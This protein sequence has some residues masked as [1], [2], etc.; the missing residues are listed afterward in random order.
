[1]LSSATPTSGTQRDAN[2]Q[3]A[4]VNE[5]RLL[6]DGR[7]YYNSGAL[8]YN[9]TP[10]SQV[11]RLNSNGTIDTTFNLKTYEVSP[12]G[13]AIQA[14]GKILA[15]GTRQNYTAGS[16]Q[17]RNGVV[18]I[19]TDGSIDTSFSP[20]GIPIGDIVYSVAVQADGKILLVGRFTSF[21][22][23]PKNSIVRLLNNAGTV[24]PAL[25]K[26]RTSDFDGDGRADASVFRSGVWYSRGSLNNNFSAVQF[27]VGRDRIVSADYDGDG[28]TDVAV[29]RNGVYFILNSAN[30]QP[31]YQYFGTAGDV[32]VASAFVQ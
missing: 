7:I 15:V 32:P 28:K 24:P 6:A 27:G 21:S 22:G 3:S 4:G 30:G 11:V 5:I 2:G 17:I 25:Q 14:D 13:L 18:R 8:V 16:P 9:G 20:A 23:T 12:V 1:M 26:N 29:W 19:N 31:S 10:V